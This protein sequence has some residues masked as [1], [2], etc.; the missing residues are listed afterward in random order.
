MSGTWRVR[1]DPR[2][3]IGSG[4]CAGAAPKHF[5]L[6]DGLSTPV[7]ELITP[8]EPVTDAADSCPVEAITVRDTADDRL[9]APEP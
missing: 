1:V 6:V 8:S 2:R 5:V 7:A 3:C 9:I 4:V